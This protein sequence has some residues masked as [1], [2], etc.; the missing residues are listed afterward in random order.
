MPVHV[1]QD[2]TTMARTTS[3][4]NVTI[5]ATSAREPRLIVIVASQDQTI[6]P[7]LQ[8]RTNAPAI[9]GFMMMA[10]ATHACNVT[11]AAINALEVRLIVTAVLQALTIERKLP[12]TSPANAI[13]DTGTTAQ[14]T[15]V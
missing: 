1:I 6:E 9:L 3:A 8:W 13:L 7:N 12:P 4:Y 5:P 11:T 15:T 14:T 2:T 10:A